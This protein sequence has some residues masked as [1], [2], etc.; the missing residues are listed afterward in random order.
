M[1]AAAPERDVSAEAYVG[2]PD[3]VKFQTRNSNT[4]FRSFCVGNQMLFNK[5][6][7]HNYSQGKY[8]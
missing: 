1:F 7:P 4:E 3:R 6:M 2:I 8:L 5:K